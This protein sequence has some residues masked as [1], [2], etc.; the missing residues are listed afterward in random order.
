MNNEKD[1]LYNTLESAMAVRTYARHILKIMGDF[2]DDT[3]AQ[4]KAIA[5]LTTS[6]C[7]HIENSPLTPLILTSVIQY[8]AGIKDKED[9][10]KN[11]NIIVDEIDTAMAETKKT[12]GKARYMADCLTGQGIHIDASDLNNE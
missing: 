7:K 10:I 5:L 12:L 9:F 6:A 3:S 2:P 1:I 8:T 4:L 11:F